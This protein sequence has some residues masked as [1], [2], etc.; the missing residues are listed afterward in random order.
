MAHDHGGGHGHG[1]PGKMHGS[2]FLISVVLNAAFVV[3][4][5]VYGLAAHSMALVADAAH[6]LSDVLGLGLAWGATVLATRLPSERRTYGFRRS[7]I[8]AALTNAILLLVAVG[9]V[10]W[11][12]IGRF[13]N[14]GKVEG[15]TVL[16][17]A[18]VG[19]GINGAAAFL[20]SKG[21]KG[22]INARGAFLHLLADAVVS[23]GVVITGALILRT[24]WMWLDPVISLII[25]VVILFGTW[26]LL[27]QSVD[28]SLD[29]VP[30]HIDIQEVKSYFAKL[31]GILEVHD[32]HVWAMST[33]ECALT[34]HLVTADSM[35]PTFLRE[36]A[37]DLEH[38]FEIHH[39]TCQLEPRESAGACKQGPDEVV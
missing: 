13:A 11:E 28:L 39:V 2:A 20:L 37:R 5:V 35:P 33:T 23:V 31:P 17:V 19:I 36:L 24:G 15:W 18:A 14:P 27:R 6:N 34:V 12:A 3:V 32:L 22:D 10:A 29:A 4:E 9:G 7:T 16:S 21:S 26:S 30:P 1:A 25:S 38:E 8:L